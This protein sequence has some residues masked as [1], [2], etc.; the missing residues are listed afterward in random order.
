MA[1]T[2]T[3]KKEVQQFLGLAGYYWRFVSTIAKPHQLTEKTAKFEWTPGC[4]AA[5][6]DLRPFWYFRTMAV[7]SPWTLLP[8]EQALET[9]V[10]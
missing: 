9:M 4:Q 1:P 7:P 10:H 6:E 3:S 5:F 8:V 2:S